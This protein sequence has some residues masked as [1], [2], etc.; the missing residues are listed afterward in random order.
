MSRSKSRSRRLVN[1]LVGA[2]L[3]SVPAGAS[4]GVEQSP[5]AA[6]PNTPYTL[7]AQALLGPDGTDV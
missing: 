3:V 5:A 6:A 2:V 1:A 4:F 7:E